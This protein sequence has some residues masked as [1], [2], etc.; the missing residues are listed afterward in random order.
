M[1]ATSM[2]EMVEERQEL[3]E[4]EIHARVERI[5]HILQENISVPVIKVY[6]E[7]LNAT[8]DLKALRG[9]LET[10]DPELPKDELDENA[11]VEQL[12]LNAWLSLILG[13]WGLFEPILKNTGRSAI[14]ILK[15]VYSQYANDIQIVSV[16]DARNVAL[17]AYELLTEFHCKDAANK[18]AIIRDEVLGLPQTRELD[19]RVNHQ[20]EEIAEVSTVQAINNRWLG[21]HSTSEQPAVDNKDGKNRAARIDSKRTKLVKPPSDY[22][23][24]KLEIVRKDGSAFAQTIDSKKPVLMI[25]RSQSADIELNDPLVSRVH[26]MITGTTPIDIKVTDLNSS[27]GSCLDGIYLKPNEPAYWDVGKPL[28]IG[29]TW[30]ILRQ[31][32]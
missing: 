15:D 28:V 20:D 24:L 17:S 23:F 26:L 5:L 22:A 3:N 10:I 2:M 25:G 31:T 32:T 6:K 29:E 11:L 14:Q 13:R 30:M 1:E 4:N 9:I 16:R 19:A 21:K 27:N 8:L 12:D 7:K 18:I